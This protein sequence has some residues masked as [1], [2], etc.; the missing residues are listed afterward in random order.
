[1][2]FNTKLIHGGRRH[3]FRELGTIVEPIFTSAVYVYHHDIDRETPH[4]LPYKY[5]REDNPTVA[6]LEE[7]VRELDSA[8]T[9]LA[10]SSGI[11]SIRCLIDSLVELWG[12][13]TLVV[14]LDLYGSTLVLF[15]KYAQ[16]GLIELI[17]VSPGTDSIVEELKYLNSSSIVVFFE[18]I[19]NP[20]LRVY[21]IEEISRTL[22][23]KNVERSLIIVDNTI[24]TQIGIRPIEHGADIVVYSASKY[25]SGHNDV[26]GGLTSLSEKVRE[27][28]SQLWHSRRLHGC[29]MSPFTAYLID[30]GLKTLHL[31]MQKHEENARAIAEFLNDHP[32]ISEVIYPGLSTH[33]DFKISVKILNNASGIVSFRLKEEPDLSRMFKKLKIIIPGVSF[34]GP[35]TIVTHPLTTTHRYLE[36]NERK[37]VGIDNK[38]FRLSI[39][40]ED[41]NDII[42]DLDNMLREV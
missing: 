5:S 25:L 4:V 14:P 37:I 1:M 9:C 15:R 23:D 3:T 42:E 8:A 19:S 7:K 26:I 35:E 11:A 17:T 36:E 34:G 39:G 41:V 32:K 22:R 40:L 27:I 31:R 21:D 2:R 6:H 30:R 24:P 12:K 16:R 18:E 13:I 33:P 10:F 38:L 29:I 28:E 20:I